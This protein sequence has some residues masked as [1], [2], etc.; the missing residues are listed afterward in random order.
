MYISSQNLVLAAATLASGVSA[1]K[2]TPIVYKVTVPTLSLSPLESK[3]VCLKGEIALAIL[4]KVNYQSSAYSFCTKVRLLGK[5]EL[6]TIDSI[7]TRDQLIDDTQDSA[8]P[9]RVWYSKSPE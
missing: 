4:T 7:L 1:L 5:K 8:N 9:V 3:L 2:A 6:R